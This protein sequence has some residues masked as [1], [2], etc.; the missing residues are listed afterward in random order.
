MKR[1]TSMKWI[2]IEKYIYLRQTRPEF[3]THSSHLFAWH[4]LIDQ[5]NHWLSHL[6][7]HFLSDWLIDWLLIKTNTIHIYS[8][9]QTP[10]EPDKSNYFPRNLSI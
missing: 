8:R 7:T 3:F 6:L 10:F 5:Q 4:G 1:D 9:D 2:V